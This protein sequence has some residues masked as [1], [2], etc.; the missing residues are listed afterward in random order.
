[1]GILGLQERRQVRLFLRR[2]HF[3][4][5]LLLPRFCTADR[6][7]TETRLGM[8][9]VLSEVFDATGLQ[10][11]VRLSESVLARLHF[12]V[13]VGAE[14]E[15]EPDVD[16]VE[17]RLADAT[18]AWADDLGEAL[19]EQLGEEEGTQLYAEYGD[20]FPARTA[21]TILPA[22]VWATSTGCGNLTPTAR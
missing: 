22:S 13:Y 16:A 20:A 19:V 17:R 18:R 9:A 21:T 3:G 11:S 14:G 5:L 7:N 4:A 8:Q 1:M 12:V 2:D 10:H 6:Y 15:L